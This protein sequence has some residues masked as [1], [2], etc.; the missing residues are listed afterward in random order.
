[1]KCAR[2]PLNDVISMFVRIIS[3]FHFSKV[4]EGK[5]HSRW[6][7]T[8]RNRSFMWSSQ[9]NWPLFW[10]FCRLIITSAK[11][12]VFSVLSVT[13]Q[14]ILK[15][16]FTNSVQVPRKTWLWADLNRVK[17][18][19]VNCEVQRQNF[20]SRLKISFSRLRPHPF[21]LCSVGRG[22]WSLSASFLA[23]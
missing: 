19:L 23:H 3:D 10:Q 13:E 9:K 6:N 15:G 22:K 12:V 18:R 20:S 14:D 21:L 2:F 4:E 1:M 7:A 11:E 16:N 17:S 5:F 8:F